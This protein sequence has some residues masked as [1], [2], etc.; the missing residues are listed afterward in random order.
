[1]DILLS[2]LSKADGSVRE[3]KSVL[4]DGLIVGRGAEE[5]V[6]LDGIDLSREHLVLTTDGTNVYVTDLSSN[7]T[8]VNGTR[9][10]R[11]VKTRVGVQDSIELPGYVL[12]FR[13]AES[14]REIGE[15]AVASPPGPAVVSEQIAMAPEP[16]EKSSPLGMLRPVFRFVGSITFMEKF[17]ILVG[18]A[19]LAWL[20]AYI[21]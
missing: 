14:P 12:T 20:Y 5:G 2:I 7:G 13:P 3:V 15:E 17:F 6:L 4:D 1:M 16:P 9:L 8:W 18:L 19:G 11:S 10:R 21:G